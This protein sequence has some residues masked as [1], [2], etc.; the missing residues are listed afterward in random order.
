MIGGLRKLVHLLS[1]AAKRNAVILL[2]LMVVG[3]LLEVV[4]L[5]AIPAF[6]GAIMDPGRLSDLPAVGGMLGGMSWESSAHYYQ[7]INRGVQQRLGPVPPQPFDAPRGARDAGDRVAAA[8]Q[9]R[10]DLA[11]N[12][13]AGADQGDLAHGV[14]LCCVDIPADAGTHLCVT[15]FPHSWER[16]GFQ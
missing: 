9:F 7:A 8:Q 6:V 11:A 12:F 16:R 3:A 4:G 2:G 15:G 5:A 14:L 13:A 1:P 10:G